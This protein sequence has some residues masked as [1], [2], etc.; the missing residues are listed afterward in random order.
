MLTV[1][2]KG[3]VHIEFDVSAYES[4]LDLDLLQEDREYE[5]EHRWA[6]D[7]AEQKH[8]QRHWPAHWFNIFIEEDE[9]YWGIASAP[10][11]PVMLIG[12]ENADEGFKEHWSYWPQS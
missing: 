7:M 6:A 9:Q 11:E 10:K 1:I 3:E 4:V 5:Q 2:Y 12:K 8:A